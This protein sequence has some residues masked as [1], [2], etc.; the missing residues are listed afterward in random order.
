MQRRNV[1]VRLQPGPLPSAPPCL[2]PLSPTPP[3][4]SRIHSPAHCAPHCCLRS[5]LITCNAA[6]WP[7]CLRMHQEG[8]GPPGHP[9]AVPHAGAGSSR[10]SRPCAACA[11]SSDAMAAPAHWLWR[12]AVML[13]PARSPALPPRCIWHDQCTGYVR[14]RKHRKRMA[15][16]QR[17]RH[18]AAVAAAAPPPPR[19]HAAAHP[20]APLQSSATTAYTI[21]SLTARSGVA[22]GACCSPVGQAAHCD[23]PHGAASRCAGR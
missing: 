17:R 15:A 6:H 2:P 13:L 12:A 3:H 5:D 7:A 10:H 14:T 9:A 20:R 1:P 22:A 11:G 19:A 18:A 23:S 8:P 21:V 16:L 4:C